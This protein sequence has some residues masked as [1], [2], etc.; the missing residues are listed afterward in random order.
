MRKKDT[1]RK[2]FVS[3]GWVAGMALTSCSSL[4]IMSFDQLQAADVSFPGAVRK[5]AVINN[6]PVVQVKENREMLSAELEGD[7]KIATEAFAENIAAVNYFDQ[8]VI[9]DSAFRAND[10]VPRV[11]VQLTQQEVRQLADDMGVDL[12]FT[13][14]RIHIH[15]KPGVLLYPDFP[16]PVNAVDAVLSPI[17]RAYVPGRDKPL[18]IV[19]K[20]DTI[21]WEMHPTLS[22]AKI[23]KEASE[24]AASIPVDH[25]LP[26]WK[27][28]T[29]YYFDGGTVEM[30]DAGVCL[31][32]NDW[33]GALALWQSAYEKKKGQARMRAAFNVALYYEVKDEV[34]KAKEW[35]DKARALAKPTSKEE[36]LMTFYALQLDARESNLS[37]LHTQMKRFEEKF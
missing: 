30:R 21:S 26:H 9:C 15:T 3:V 33:E 37:K 13:L 23:V 36:Q 19:A 6:M 11:N 2:W 1:M 24:Y 10:K 35:L 8:V 25:L 31:R 14:D 17:V 27:E 32:E 34:A 29:R 16:M 4:Q 28:I 20:Q 22:D 18:F 5:V 7:G 12:L